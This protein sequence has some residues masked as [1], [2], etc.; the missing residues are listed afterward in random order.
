[1]DI[2]KSSNF[3]INIDKLNGIPDD[4][5]YI[6]EVR[7]IRRDFLKMSSSA[8]PEVALGMNGDG[9][10]ETIWQGLERRGYVTGDI[11]KIMGKNLY[12]L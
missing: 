2:N 5:F 8:V 6:R 3:M 10:M 7:M 9:C 11:E 1:M 12:R 4:N